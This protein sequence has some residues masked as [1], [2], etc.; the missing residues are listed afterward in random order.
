MLETID[1]NKVVSIEMEILDII[2][3]KLCLLRIVSWSY[4]YLQMINRYK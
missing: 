4:D 1:S 2:T 3:Y